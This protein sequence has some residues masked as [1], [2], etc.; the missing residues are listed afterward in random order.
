MWEN[1]RQSEQVEVAFKIVTLFV[2][3]IKEITK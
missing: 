3:I 1:V 2:G